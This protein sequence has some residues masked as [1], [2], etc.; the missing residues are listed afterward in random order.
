[1]RRSV[2]I[3]TVTLALSL[4]PAI[5]VAQTAQQPPAGQPPAGQPPAGQPP[6][7]TPPPAAQA[8]AAP[9]VA[10]TTDAG[11]L[12]VQIKPDQTAAF[13]E[14][15]T[16]IRAGAAKASDPALKQQL[17]TL[18]VYKSSEPMAG[19][20]LYVVVADPVLKAAEYE[21]LTMLQKL[22]TPDELR[23]PESQEM[24]KKFVAAFAAGYSKLSLTPLAGGM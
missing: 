8:P 4:A 24:F 23:T 14:L 21:L 5:L 1:M 22:M 16:K 18:K 12:L 20:A 15:I 2:V 6:A 9:K 7:G 11:I 17:S 10:F 19:N 3:T 13:E